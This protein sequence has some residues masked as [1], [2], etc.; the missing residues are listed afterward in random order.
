MGSWTGSGRFADGFPKTANNLSGQTRQPPGK[1]TPPQNCETFASLGKTISSILI[2]LPTTQHCVCLYRGFCSLPVFGSA[3]PLRLAARS[4]RSYQKDAENRICTSRRAWGNHGRESEAHTKPL[5]AGEEQKERQGQEGCERP[6][7]RHQA[8]AADRCQC[9]QCGRCSRNSRSEWQGDIGGMDTRSDRVHASAVHR[10][11]M[12]LL[13]SHLCPG[14]R[15]FVTGT[16][17]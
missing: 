7:Q 5:H 9:V 13:A 11:S 8:T 4:S 16:T 3:L 12:G 6:R 10:N 14:D 15:P 2:T 17:L 1:N